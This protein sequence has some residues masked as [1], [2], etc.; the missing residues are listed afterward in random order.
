MALSQPRIL[1]KRYELKEPIGEG[2]FSVTYR[3]TDTVLGR[4]VA[5]KILRDQYASH[6][7]FASRFENEARAAARISHPNVI[8]VFDYGRDDGTTYIV[9]QYVLGPSLKDYIREEGPLTVDEAVGFGRQMLDGLAAIHASGIVHRDVKPQNVLLTDTHQ[10][11]VTDFGIARLRSA[12]AGLTEAGTAIGTAA[13]MAPEQASGA[14]IT[15][16]SDLYSAG[17][18]V[19]EMLTGRLPFPGD[20]PVQVMYRH[21]NELPPPPR[22]IN[23]SIPV[24]LEAVILKSLAKSPD[25]RYPD[26]IAMRDALLNPTAAAAVIRPP[27][28]DPTERTAVSRAIAPPAVAG[29]PPSM[30]PPPARPAA[31]GGGGSWWRRILP[32]L[33]F[34]LL[35][36]V[37]ALVVLASQGNDKTNA[38]GIVTTPTATQTAPPATM[39][40]TIEPTVTITPSPTPEPTQ[41]PSPTPEPTQTPSPTPE[42]TQTPIPEPTQTPEPPTPTVPSVPTVAYDTPF[43]LSLVPQRIF[44]GPSVT[45]NASDF[46][47][48]YRRDDGRLYGLPAAHLYG[49]GSGSDTGTATFQA[50]KWPSQYILVTVTG[51]DDEKAAHVPMQLWLND[52]LIWEGPSPFNN[53]SWTDVAWLVGDLNALH[54]GENTLTIVNTAKNGVVGQ[55]PWILITTAAVYYQ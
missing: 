3:A 55:A 43:P 22:T 34:L 51:M 21:V 35:A 26:A 16:A 5:I 1:G 46:E 47:G 7:E 32:L 29:P 42:P 11:K 33:V 15:P 10:V 40:A 31:G 38:P 41:T 52:Y 23:R 44:Q 48:A 12:D 17:V 27:A 50:T 28:F 20:N 8:Q 39:T 6:G 53:E 54:A 37:V 36:V 30:P 9:M 4:D 49:Q 13:Y 2:N 25:D 14:E 18:V 19:Y 45:L 24:A